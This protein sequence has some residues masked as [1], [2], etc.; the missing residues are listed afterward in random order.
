M[1]EASWWIYLAK[2]NPG[3]AGGYPGDRAR[4]GARRLNV[5]RLGDG[6]GRWHA[7]AEEVGEHPVELFGW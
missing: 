5:M 3:S 6:A 2:Q 1:C 7:G 4:S